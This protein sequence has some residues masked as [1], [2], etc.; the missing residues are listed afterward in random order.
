MPL[1]L[2]AG[3]E[4]KQ[5]KNTHKKRIQTSNSRNRLIEPTTPVSSRL[6]ILSGVIGNINNENENRENVYNSRGVY[7]SFNEER[8]GNRRAPRGNLRLVNDINDDVRRALKE[9]ENEKNMKRN[10]DRIREIYRAKRE[11]VPVE[12]ENK[13]KPKA[14]KTIRYQYNCKPTDLNKKLNEDDKDDNN[15]ND[16]DN[17]N[18]NNLN[19]M[20]PIT[21]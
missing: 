10:E 7:R 5:E 1:A 13:L 9:Y 20:E 6:M 15:D 21:A 3:K 16:F 12:I 14:K 18:N 17:N 11:P 19:N 2:N 8:T 4:K